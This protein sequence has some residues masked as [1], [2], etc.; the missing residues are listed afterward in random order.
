MT[1]PDLASAARAMRN[2]ACFSACSTTM[3]GRTGHAAVASVTCASRCG[4][5]GTTTSIGPTR[6][7][8]QRERLAEDA[9]E[10]RDLAAAAARQHQHDRRIGQPAPRLGLVRAQLRNLLDQRM[11]DIAARRAAEPAMHVGLE[12]QQRQHMVDVAAHRARARPARQA[13]TDG[14]T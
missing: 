10:P 12:R 9:G 5:V 11:A 1:V 6:S 3:R 14:E 7:L 8:Q 4:T 2:A 13:Q